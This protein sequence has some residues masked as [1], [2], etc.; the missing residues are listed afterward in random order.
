MSRI[1]KLFIWI[2]AIFFVLI[3]AF[4]I[5]VA[6]FLHTINLKVILQKQVRQQ[7]GHTLSIKGPF[8][9]HV[10][11]SISLSADHVYL[12]TNRPFKNNVLLKVKHMSTGI[13]LLPL[14][15]G[16][17]ELK[18]F[19]LK[20]ATLNL[21]TTRTGKKNWQPHR[22]K[23]HAHKE[24]RSHAH[25]NNLPTLILPELLIK[26]VSINWLDQKT[27][28]HFRLQHLNVQASNI[29]NSKRFPIKASI[30]ID[31]TKPVVHGKIAFT[32]Q[33]FFSNRRIEITGHLQAKPLKLQKI[34]INS[35][36]SDIK[37]TNQSIFLQ[38]LK[39]RLYQGT[40]QAAGQGNFQKN[41]YRLNATITHINLQPLL[42][43][44]LGHPQFR[45]DASARI[46]L[47]TQGNAP[48]QFLQNL[49]GSGKLTVLNGQY[50]GLD[51]SALYRNG[52]NMIRPH[53]VKP[54]KNTGITKFGHLTGSFNLRQGNLTSNDLLAQSP[55]L[56]IKGAGF[57]NLVT[58][59]LKWRFRVMALQG[60]LDNPK[61]IGPVIP[62]NLSG[63]FTHY[64]FQP[65]L[66]GLLKNT[67]Q[68]TVQ[69]QLK[70][71][72]KKLN[73]GSLFG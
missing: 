72:L 49:N 73:L 33:A 48:K 20:D 54:T 39:A 9:W 69:H 42:K 37:I 2:I 4:F 62:F 56:Q 50:Q 24:K 6:V 59:R 28:Q 26:N 63:T 38:S 41:R 61:P 70:R 23:Q 51:L 34:V 21:I 46:N 44:L 71:Q 57:A 11:P 13:Q 47:T 8:D 18:K 43:G 58:Q 12:K 32:G 27:N 31:S 3:F 7:T 68:T 1:S 35:L 53:S 22:E 17:I 25:D 29:Q 45:G 55:I 66:S 67:L 16:K 15:A 19:I 64:R 10:F 40:L 14:F 30:Q 52:L 5:T 36:Q 60:S 65:D